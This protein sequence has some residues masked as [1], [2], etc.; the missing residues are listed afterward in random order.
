MDAL[1][2]AVTETVTAAV[3]G[4]HGQNCLFYFIIYCDRFSQVNLSC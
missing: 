2:T 3:K 1:T 4:L